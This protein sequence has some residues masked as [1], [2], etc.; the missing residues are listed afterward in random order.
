M[1][2]IVILGDGMADYP[3]AELG[4][5][6]PL[7]YAKKP[8]ID[9]L[10]KSAEVGL[11]K[12][13]PEGFPPGSDVANLSVMGYDP[14]KYYTGRSPLEA[15][16]L[17]VELGPDD[18]AFRCNLVTLSK[19]KVYEEKTMVDY[20]SQEISS[21]ESAQLM[22]SIEQELGGGEFKFYPGISYRHLMVWKGGPLDGDLTPPHDISDRK[23]TDFLPKGTGSDVL[24]T[25]MKK[26]YDILNVHPV[27]QVRKVKGLRPAV[28]IWLWGQGKKPDLTGFEEKFNL[29]GSMVS[30]V[31]LTKG[32]GK[33]AG[34]NVVKVPGATGNI[35]TNFL[36][37]AEAALAEL[38]K[39]QDFVYV[40]VEAPDEAGHQGNINDKVKAIEEI[41]E[42]VLGTILNGLDQIKDDYRIMILPDHPTPVSIKTHTGEIVP[43]L[44]FDSR[45]SKESGILC[46]DEDSARQ[47]GILIEPGHELMNRFING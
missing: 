21:E 39:G 38:K 43:Y 8:N 33:C 45:Y 25:L 12:T 6:T 34:L 17:G 35:H 20:S 41:D 42:K 37:K 46:Y 3:L 15:V 7:Q 27:N 9:K 19:E 36:G 1:K 10:A 11:V 14:Q 2:Y 5:R 31:D 26:S 4:G 29:V 44:I 28:S 24:L 30:A 32:L 22:K 40:H 23:I 47:S 13:V 18:V 16:S